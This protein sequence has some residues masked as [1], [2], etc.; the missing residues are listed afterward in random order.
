VQGVGYMN[1]INLDLSMV[2]SMVAEFEKTGQK[3]LYNFMLTILTAG[4]VWRDP[5]IINITHAG[6]EAEFDE[7]L[8]NRLDLIAQGKI[9][10]A[11]KGLKNYSDAE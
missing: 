5:P 4:S 6:E 2:L 1:E 11:K 7:E 9:S 8:A 3:N 10:Q